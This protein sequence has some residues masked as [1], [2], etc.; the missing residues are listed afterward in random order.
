MYLLYKLCLKLFTKRIAIITTVLASIIPEFIYAVLSYTPTIIYHFFVISLFLILFIQEYNTKYVLLTGILIGFIIYFRTEFVLFAVI[1]ILNY[2][3]KK[4]YKYS[5]IIIITLIILIFPWGLRNYF[6]F[7]KFIL[8]TTS[9]GLNL[10]RGN[11]PYSI[12]AWGDKE[13]YNEI[14]NLE[15]DDSFEINMN[16]IY[17]NKAY[18]FIKNN[19]LK[20]VE[21]TALKF[22]YFWIFNSNEKRAN[23]FLYIIPTIFLLISFIYGSIKS[24]SW[25][26]YNLFYLFFIYSSLIA[27]IFFPMLRYQTM[28]KIMILPFC[29]YGIEMFYNSV[30]KKLIYM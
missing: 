27:V 3:I 24:F 28:M 15:R 13:I 29:A 20:F 18:N 7:N 26:K 14:N 22:E 16:R 9:Y 10:Y 30:I 6:I 1:L 8:F 11:N 5:A 21:N 12:G 4:N 2:F 25:K 19:P 23:N 17:E